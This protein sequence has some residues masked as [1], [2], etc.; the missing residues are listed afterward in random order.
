MPIALCR[1]DDRLVHGQVVVGWGA[2]LRV[3]LIV[4]V[5]DAVRSNPW[6][7]EIYRMAVPGGVALEFASG[8]EAAARLRQ[9]ATG[10]DRVFIL[11]GD[12]ATMAD[13]V[14]AGDGVIN[15]VNLGGLHDVPGRRERLRYLYLSEDEISQLRRLEAAGIIITAQD[16]PTATPIAFRE[17][18][19]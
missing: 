2:P 15:R 7:Q 4:L 8:A 16:V 11:T 17:L 10:Q 19:R 1:V 3:D 14:L 6:E 13:L 18:L 9:W 5:D 12:I